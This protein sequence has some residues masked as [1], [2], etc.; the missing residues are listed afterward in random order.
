VCER[1]RAGGEI[2]EGSRE[3]VRS[4]NIVRERKRESGRK[5]ARK[6]RESD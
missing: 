2:R 5:Q 3:R 4:I 6:K 1:D